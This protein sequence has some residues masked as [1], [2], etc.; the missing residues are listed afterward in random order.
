MELPCRFLR[1]TDCVVPLA[2]AAAATNKYSY[3]RRR[4]GGREREKEDCPTSIHAPVRPSV[5]RWLNLNWAAAARAYTG[6]HTANLNSDWLR[7]GREGIGGGEREETESSRETVRAV[8][9]TKQLRPSNN[10]CV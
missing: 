2:R 3:E 9:V 7:G 1:P 8:I 4:R 6:R 5:R 10:F